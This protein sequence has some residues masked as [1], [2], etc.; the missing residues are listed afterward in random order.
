MLCFMCNAGGRAAWVGACAYA[1]LKFAPIGM[2]MPH[3]T[4]QPVCRSATVHILPANNA[5]PAPHPGQL[6]AST[7]IHLALGRHIVRFG[8]QLIVGVY[9]QVVCTCVVG[10]SGA[11]TWQGFNRYVMLKHE[12]QNH[13]NGATAPHRPMW[14]PPF[15][16]MDIISYTVLTQQDAT[17][18][19]GALQASCPS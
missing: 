17:A 9:G 2:H 4:S 6:A 15:T 10:R 7:D 18:G 19:C 8:Q 3:G 16:F 1:T 13:D 12:L 11:E 5:P 14:L